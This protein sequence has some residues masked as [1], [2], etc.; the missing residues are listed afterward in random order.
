MA[1]SDDKMTMIVHQ[2]VAIFCIYYCSYP[3]LDKIVNGKF[4]PVLLWTIH[5]GTEEKESGAEKLQQWEEEMRGEKKVEPVKKDF[6]D[7]VINESN[8]ANEQSQG[9]KKEGEKE[10]GREIK[11]WGKDKRK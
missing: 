9:G 6:T 3:I 8:A 11:V 10:K 7:D 2:K 4:N 1:L 5:R